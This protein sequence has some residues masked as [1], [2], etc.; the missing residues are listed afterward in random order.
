MAP[1]TKNNELGLFLSVALMSPTDVDS[2][3][4][5]ETSVNPFAFS[6]ATF[7]FVCPER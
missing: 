3:R 1:P 7:P 6:S 2:Q 5:D 4:I